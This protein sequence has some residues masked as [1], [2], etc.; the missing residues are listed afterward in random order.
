MPRITPGTV[1]KLLIMS[2]LVGLVLA[3]LN[4]DPQNIL[5]SARDGVEALMKMGVDF[6]GWAFKYVLIGAV[7]VVPIWLALFL[8]RYLRGKR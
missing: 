6:F 2:L 1:V 4:I 5:Q 3:F 7:V 8:W